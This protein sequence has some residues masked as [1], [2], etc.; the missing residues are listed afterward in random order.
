M[1]YDKC[2]E[3]SSKCTEYFNC[4]INRPEKKILT[5]I[6]QF[7]CTNFSPYVPSSYTLFNPLEKFLES[8]VTT[9]LSLSK[10][11]ENKERERERG[12]TIIL[13]DLDEISSKKSS[14]SRRRSL[15]S[16]PCVL[17][18]RSKVCVRTRHEGDSRT[19]VCV[20]VGACVG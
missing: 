13:I 8:N 6:T 4:K 19:L 5:I 10:K 1:E 12:D 17:H 2:H 3:T 11:E 16:L 15:R 7:F 18:T 14:V 9:S 20:G